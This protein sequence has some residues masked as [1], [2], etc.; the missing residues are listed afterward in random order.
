MFYWP[1]D[2]WTKATIVSTN[3]GTP[4]CIGPSPKTC[5]TLKKKHPHHNECEWLF[6]SRCD[7]D[8]NIK[9]AISSTALWINIDLKITQWTYPQLEEQARHSRSFYWGCFTDKAQQETEDPYFH[10]PVFL[11]HVTANF[12]LHNLK[13]VVVRPHTAQMQ[14]TPV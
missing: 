9:A 6:H 1:K 2:I 3:I 11:G 14:N 4:V 7:A 5:G 10:K 8:Y 13:M 12:Q